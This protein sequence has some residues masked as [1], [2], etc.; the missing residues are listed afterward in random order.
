MKRFYKDVSTG[1][2]TAGGGF[3]I[4]LDGRP[5]RTPNKALLL[6][7][8]DALAQAVAQEWARQGEVVMPQSMPLTTLLTTAIDRTIPERGPITLSVLQYLNG[9]LIC[10]RSPAGVDTGLDAEEDRVWAPWA[11]WFAARYGHRLHTTTDLNALTQSDDAHSD[12]AA[13]LNGLD[14]HR[15][16]VLQ[17][18]TSLSGSLVLALAFLEGQLDAQGIYDAALCEEQFFARKH[19]LSQYGEDPITH[20]KHAALLADLQACRM[21]LDYL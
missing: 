11:D 13:Y 14:D 20:K 17:V 2:D 16:N 9:D 5:V 10:Y 7:P 12:I 6:S 15:F 19:D 1:P 3:C 4:L 21:Y 18:V 8:S